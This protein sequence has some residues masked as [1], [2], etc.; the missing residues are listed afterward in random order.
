MCRKAAAT[1]DEGIIMPTAGRV[2][3][4]AAMVMLDFGLHAAVDSGFG[5]LRFE[6]DAKKLEIETIFL[7]FELF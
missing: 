4:D 1:G 5:S 3:D 2:G 6:A 7:Y